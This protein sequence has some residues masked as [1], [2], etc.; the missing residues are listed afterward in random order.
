MSKVMPKRCRNHWSSRPGALAVVV[1]A[2][3]VALVWDLG[4]ALGVVEVV[5]EEKGDL[6]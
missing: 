2:V 4:W 3:V 6:E 5:M 1:L